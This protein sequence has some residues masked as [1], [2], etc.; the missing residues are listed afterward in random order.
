L[1]DTPGTPALE[2]EVGTSQHVGRPIRR[3]AIHGENLRRVQQLESALGFDAYLALALQMSAVS[4]EPAISEVTIDP[5]VSEVDNEDDY[6]S[7]DIRKPPNPIRLSNSAPQTNLMHLLGE[8]DSD[9]FQNDD[10]SSGDL[11]SDQN[12]VEAVFSDNIRVIGDRR[13]GIGTT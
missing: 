2:L 8:D 4:S 3:A 9:I 6:L 5:Q 7:T 10:P 1:H 12:C 11:F 13:C